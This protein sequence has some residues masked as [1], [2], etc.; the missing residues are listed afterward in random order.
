M[1]LKTFVTGFV[2]A[3]A[4]SAANKANGQVGINT[5]SPD[6]NSALDIVHT[7]KGVLIPRLT[8]TQVND[9]AALQPADGM[10]LYNST[11]QCI[12]IFKRISPTDGAFDCLVAA[13]G[14]DGTNDAWINDKSKTQVKLGTLSDGAT[15]RPAGTEFLVK[16]DG[17][18]G[19]G[20]AL[21]VATLHI[22]KGD[23]RLENEDNWNGYKGITYSDAKYPQLFL[24][25][26]RGTKTSPTY[27]QNGTTLGV[28]KSANAIDQTGGAGFRI[29]STEQQTASTHGSSLLI[30]TTPNG[31]SDN[32]DRFIVDHNGNVGIGTSTPSA[33][34][35][36]NGT[37]EIA[38]VNNVPN[39][40][41]YKPLVWNTSTQRVETTA[42][43]S[44]IKRINANVESGATVNIGSAF[45]GAAT[46]SSYEIKISTY[47]GCGV[48]AYNKFLATGTATGFWRINHISGVSENG[49][50]TATVSGNGSAVTVTN[51]VSGCAAGGNANSLSYRL[52]ISNTGQLSIT[53]IGD[54]NRTYKTIIEKEID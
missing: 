8:Q 20:T 22:E 11:A 53:N 43:N 9:L 48:S 36:V 44:G 42:D 34:L 2:F 40:T 26:A 5:T 28:F 23:F 52:N 17:K 25:Q 13:G 27:P 6:T 38:T 4:F 50:S 33:T 46:G 32:I 16:D 49:P 45:S 7:K 30:F 54:I 15:A 31:T 3:I 12:Q 29:K 18:V 14:N 35:D 47:N 24:F 19:I 10:L 51:P 21:P 37:V 39:N 1:D 41:A